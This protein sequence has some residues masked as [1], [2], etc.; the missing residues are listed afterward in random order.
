MA[1]QVTA[2]FDGTTVSF[3]ATFTSPSWPAAQVSRSTLRFLTAG[4]LDTFLTDAGF[5]ID[6]RYGDWDAGPF[7]PTS[8]EIITIATPR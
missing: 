7:T 2:P 6:A 8:P 5:T 4:A 3:T 1:H